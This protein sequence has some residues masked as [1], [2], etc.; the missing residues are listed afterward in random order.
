ML[1]VFSPDGIPTWEVRRKMKIESG[2][3]D[4]IAN[5]A[6]DTF[7]AAQA[8]ALFAAN[9]WALS[10][11]ISIGHF[12]HRIRPSASMIREQKQCSSSSAWRASRQYKIYSDNAVA[13]GPKSRRPTGRLLRR[14]WT[15]TKDRFIS[16]AAAIAAADKG[17]ASRW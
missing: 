16:S 14:R 10:R 5:G 8:A 1:L 2:G 9:A 11:Q 17:L 13:P 3:D 4:L 15:V 12:R 7:Q 6:A